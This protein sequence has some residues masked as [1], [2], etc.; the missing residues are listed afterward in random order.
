MIVY[1]P[2]GIQKYKDDVVAHFVSRRSN[3]LPTHK[4]GGLLSTRQGDFVA[5]IP[6]R[7][8]RDGMGIFILKLNLS[9]IG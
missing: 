7:V 8:F 3:Q 1:I 5:P 9:P 4:T 6:S 2:G